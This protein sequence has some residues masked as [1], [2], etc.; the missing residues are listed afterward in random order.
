MVYCEIIAVV[1]YEILF[2]DSAFIFLFERVLCEY[3]QLV[4]KLLHVYYVVLLSA[5]VVFLSDFSIKE[6]L[7]GEFVE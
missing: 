4:W 5:F 2:N 7:L 6:E 3:N 1:N